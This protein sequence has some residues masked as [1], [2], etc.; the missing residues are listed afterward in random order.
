MLLRCETFVT[1]ILALKN[2]KI[3]LGI[4]KISVA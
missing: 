1:V 4:V 2:I 3:I